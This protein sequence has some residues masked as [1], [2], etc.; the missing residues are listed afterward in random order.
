MPLAMQGISVRA[1]TTL[2][3]PLDRMHLQAGS[4]ALP[5]AHLAELGQVDRLA[6]LCG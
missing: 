1:Q 5:P 3:I 6:N 4:L 2:R